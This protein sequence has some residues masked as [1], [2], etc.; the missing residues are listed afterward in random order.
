MS[1]DK[2]KRIF[3]KILNIPIIEVTSDLSPNSC[4]SWDSF[5]MIKLVLAIEEKFEIKLEIEEVVTVTNFRDMVNI[6]EKKIK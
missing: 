1:Q 3:S 2:L 4:S 6:V 5:N